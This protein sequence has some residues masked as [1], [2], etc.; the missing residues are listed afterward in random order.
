[1]KAETSLRTKN[2]EHGARKK[3]GKKP[4]SGLDRDPTGEQTSLLFHAVRVAGG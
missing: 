3:G 2:E 4:P 1:M